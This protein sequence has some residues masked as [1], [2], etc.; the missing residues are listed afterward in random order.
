[1]EE[2][3]GRV[4][5]SDEGK[6]KKINSWIQNIGEIHQKQPPATATY[7]KPMPDI[8]TLMQEWPSEIED[9]LRSSKLPKEDLVWEYSGYLFEIIFLVVY[10]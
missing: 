2:V 7:S 8:E 9:L 6:C 4:E 3:V 10:S 5:H 1:M